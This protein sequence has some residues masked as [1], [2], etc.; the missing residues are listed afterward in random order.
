MNKKTKHQENEEENLRGFE[1][2]IEGQAE[3]SRNQKTSG[4]IS[5]KNDAEFEHLTFITTDSVRLTKI[6]NLL[7][8]KVPLL[9]KFDQSDNLLSKQKNLREELK[10]QIFSFVNNDKSSFQKSMS[11][12]FDS[13]FEEKKN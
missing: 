4:N 13:Y 10:D 11:E 6:K 7:K 9:S 8:E 2:F 1:E 3:I 5:K 12:I